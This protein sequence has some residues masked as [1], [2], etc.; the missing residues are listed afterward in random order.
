MGWK[1]V[2]GYEN[3]ETIDLMRD[4]EGTTT[5]FTLLEVKPDV[6][7]YRSTVYNVQHE[8]VKKQFWGST[9]IDRVLAEIQ[10]GAVVTLVYKGVQ[11]SKERGKQPF[12]NF[13][14][15]VEDPSYTL[16]DMGTTAKEEA[17][18]KKGKV[19]F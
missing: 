7:Q 15:F 19:P 16:N 12:K 17:P 3:L 2:G 4:G 9:V 14:A 11:P 1:R 6:G 5:T 8:G 13:E 18:K 10:I